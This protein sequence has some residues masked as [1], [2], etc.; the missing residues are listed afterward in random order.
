MRLPPSVSSA[1]PSVL[2]TNFE[3]H[4]VGFALGSIGKHWE[5]LAPVQ[6][7]RNSEF[8][9]QIAGDLVQATDT[10][11]LMAEGSTLQAKNIF[12]Q[13]R[14]PPHMP[15]APNRHCVHMCGHTAV[16]TALDSAQCHLS[17][18]RRMSLSSVL[19]RCKCRWR[20]QRRH[21]GPWADTELE[22][23][24]PGMCRSTLTRTS[25]ASRSAPPKSTSRLA[26]QSMV[27]FSPRLRSPSR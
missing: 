21:L 16:S 19:L 5:H 4:K 15:T 9:V 8:G 6:Q 11:V 25:R 24:L 7:T 22:C 20:S 1:V 10:R 18:R 13:A 23:R 27:A 2:I 3:F 17:C 12:W 26:H 14:T